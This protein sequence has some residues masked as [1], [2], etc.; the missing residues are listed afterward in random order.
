M[1]TSSKKPTALI[2]DDDEDLCTL[3]SLNLRGFFVIH[4]EHTIAGGQEYLAHHRIS[5]LLLDNALPDGKGLDL[6]KMLDKA[7]EETKVVLMTGD[8][9]PDI[10][11]QALHD[12][13]SGFIPKPFGINS[14][15]QMVISLFPELWAA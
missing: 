12:G 11:E 15:R 14:L 10:K 3:L 6:L 9:A 4:V 5:L 1:K 8:Q 13:A 7:K 2:I